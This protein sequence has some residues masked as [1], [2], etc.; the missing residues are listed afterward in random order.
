MRTTF[1]SKETLGEALVQTKEPKPE[2]K[3]K[4]VV[5]TRYYAPNV[6]VSAV[7]KPEVHLKRD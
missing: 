7:E 4:G 5:C 3:K 6:I 2:W 1:K